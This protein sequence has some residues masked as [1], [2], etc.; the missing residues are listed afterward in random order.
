M[1][2]EKLLQEIDKMHQKANEALAQKQFDTYISIFSDQLEYKQINGKTIDKRTLVKDT[3]R[4]F[5]RL[6]TSSSEYERKDYSF[7]E[8]RFTE[9]LIQK[10]IAS[11][12]VFIF[13]TKKWTVEREA[14]YQWGNHEGKWKIE[15]VEILNEKVY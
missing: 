13:F 4:Y 2:N 8:N 6:K 15:K 1:E 5:G 11:I 9:N 10:A 12:R 14:V 7:E 3:S